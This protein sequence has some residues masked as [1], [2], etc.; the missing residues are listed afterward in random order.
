MRTTCRAAGPGWPAGTRRSATVRLT[1]SHPGGGPG[2]DG[3][4]DAACAPSRSEQLGYSPA[5]MELSRYPLSRLAD[6]VG[7]PFYLYDAS[8]LRANLAKLAS[9]GDGTGGQVKVRYAM[10]ANSSR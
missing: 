9:L 3:P 7:T 5:P 1:P 2:W 10:K 8:I 4:A 6:Q